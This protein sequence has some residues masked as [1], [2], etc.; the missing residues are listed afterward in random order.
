[1]SIIRKEEMVDLAGN[2]VNMFHMND[3][4]QI[5]LITSIKNDVELKRLTDCIPHFDKFMKLRI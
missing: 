2:N 4:F 5:A 1:M 3:K